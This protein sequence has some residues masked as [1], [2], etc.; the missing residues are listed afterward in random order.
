MT[1]LADRSAKAL[2]ELRQLPVSADQIA[3]GVE[4]L[5]STGVTETVRDKL[6]SI[7]ISLPAVNQLEKALKTRGIEAAKD[8]LSNVAKLHKY[9]L[10]AGESAL[11]DSGR[12]I[13]RFSN[14]LPQLTEA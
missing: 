9:C 13:A 7:G 8:L 12:W 6:L 5:R 10:L 11:A 2:D 1:L 14:G 4:E 3:A